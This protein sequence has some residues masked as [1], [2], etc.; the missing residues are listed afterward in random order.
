[1]RMKTKV[2]YLSLF[3]TV[4][5]LAGSIFSASAQTN[6]AKADDLSV[7]NM[8]N[9]NKDGKQ[10]IYPSQNVQVVVKTPQWFY[11]NPSLTKTMNFG[12][13][14]DMNTLYKFAY[15]GNQKVAYTDV[16]WIAADNLAIVSEFTNMDKYQE[17]LKQPIPQLKPSSKIT[18]KYYTEFVKGNMGRIVIKR[19]GVKMYKHANTKA[20]QVKR[21]KKGT[22]LYVSDLM[23]N[24]HGWFFIVFNSNGDDNDGYVSSNKSQV[25]FS[26][27][28]VKTPGM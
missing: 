27:K 20:K 14:H 4:F 8:L 19:N 7:I 22:R 24:K 23:H 12:T 15:Y 16:G 26:G 18:K 2:S 11:D 5:G 1:M 6:T 10:V 9:P 17:L 28:K 3:A 21:L 25:Y 13:N